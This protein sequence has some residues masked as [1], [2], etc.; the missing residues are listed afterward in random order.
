MSEAFAKEDDGS[1]ER[2]EFDAEKILRVAAFIV[3]TYGENAISHALR[4]ESQSAVVD[5]A[6]RVRMEVERLV[7]ASMSSSEMHSASEVHL[8][9]EG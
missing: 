9:N 1:E 4:L 3:S 5:M 7:E 2:T 6:R 8:P